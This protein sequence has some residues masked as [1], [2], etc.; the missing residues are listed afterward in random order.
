M[1]HISSTPA[2]KTPGLRVPSEKT[3]G[4]RSTPPLSTSCVVFSPPVG[5]PSRDGSF[6]VSASK[7]PASL[8]WSLLTL[9]AR[10]C[11]LGTVGPPPVDPPILALGEGS[12]PALGPALHLPQRSGHLTPVSTLK[13]AIPGRGT[14]GGLGLAPSEVVAPMALSSPLCFRLEGGSV[15]TPCVEEISGHRHFVSRRGR[16]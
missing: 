10:T 4:L 9:G 3:P 2:V 12:C 15:A 13:V 11:L 8:G 14:R 1:S 5:V 6:G 16:V 7:G